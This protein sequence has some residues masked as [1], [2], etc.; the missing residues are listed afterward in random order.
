MMIADQI[1]KDES[2]LEKAKTL[3]SMIEIQIA[4]NSV[5]YLLLFILWKCIFRQDRENFSELRNT[6]SN[7]GFNGRER[8]RERARMRNAPPLLNRLTGQR[9]SEEDN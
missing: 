8:R 9:F 5:Y 6:V 2:L 7:A 1:Y 4:V 3:K